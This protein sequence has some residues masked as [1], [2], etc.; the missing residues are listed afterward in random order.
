MK[1]VDVKVSKETVDGKKE[2]NIT[3]SFP[4][5]GYVV[6]RIFIFL[7]TLFAISLITFILISAAPGDPAETMLNLNS[8]EGQVSNKL[9][10]DKSYQDLRIKLGLDLPVFYFTPGSLAS[11]D[12]LNRIAKAEQRETLERMI[13]NYG[14]WKQIERYYS[15]LCAF[16][17][18]VL[19][20]AKD[21]ASA[22]SLIELRNNVGKLYLQTDAKSINDILLKCNMLIKSS[23]S[24]AG[25]NTSLSA[26]QASID[27]VT[28]QATT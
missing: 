10:T 25:L 24:F 12:T 3:I 8:G 19:S 16:D 17:I 14:D 28:T 20:T 21:S 22:T 23:P 11:C 26:V 4:L 2:T 27:L 9:A 6:R 7:P 18:A 5:F 1:P 15:S 13:Y